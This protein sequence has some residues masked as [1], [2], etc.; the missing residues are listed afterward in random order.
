MINTTDYFNQSNDNTFNVVFHLQIFKNNKFAAV[1]KKG[2]LI[3]ASSISA[4]SFHIITNINYQN[5]ICIIDSIS[6]EECMHLYQIIVSGLQLSNSIDVNIKES[7]KEHFGRFVVLTKHNYEKLFETIN[8][9]I[10]EL[11]LIHLKTCI[12]DPEQWVEHLL[13]QTSFIANTTKLIANKPLYC[14]GIKA[15]DKMYYSLVRL[16]C[17]DPSLDHLIS[18]INVLINYLPRYE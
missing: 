8:Q 1:V 5:D 13:Q 4:P 9:S 2:G 18:N 10:K 11:D 6:L 16:R 3:T 7:I 17:N 12:N 15:L 14:I